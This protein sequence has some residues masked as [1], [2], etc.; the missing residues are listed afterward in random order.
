MLWL[1]QTDTFPTKFEG[2]SSKRVSIEDNIRFLLLPLWVHSICIG[3]F[4]FERTPNAEMLSPDIELIIMVYS[5]SKLQLPIFVTET[6][7]V[8]GFI[9]KCGNIQRATIV[10]MA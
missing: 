9:W 8:S 6:N 3:Y 1:L 4:D 10:H 2:C 5:V 7:F